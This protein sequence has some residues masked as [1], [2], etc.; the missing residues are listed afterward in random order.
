[1]PWEKQGIITGTELD[2]LMSAPLEKSTSTTA[3]WSLATAA[4]SASWRAVRALQCIRG[5]RIPSYWSLWLRLPQWGDGQC[6][7]TLPNR[8]RVRT[9]AGLVRRWVK[10]LAIQYFF[11]FSYFHAETP[12]RIVLRFCCAV[13]VFSLCLLSLSFK[14]AVKDSRSVLW[15]VNF[16]QIHEIRLRIRYTPTQP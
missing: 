15:R 11:S 12:T 2:A 13:C 5:T 3:A 1:M 7:L 4:K 6:P 9:V 8:R 10:G 16:H 14:A